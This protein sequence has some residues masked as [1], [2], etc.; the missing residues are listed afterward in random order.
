MGSLILS[1]MLFFGAIAPFTE[2]GVTDFDTVLSILNPVGIWESSG[3]EPWGFR[4]FEKNGW[5]PLT[6]GH[7]IYSDFGWFWKGDGAH[8]W[9]TDHYGAWKCGEEGTWRWFP[10]T[11]WYPSGVDWRGTK[12][13][14]GWRFSAINKKG[15]FEETEE[16]RVAR[17]EEWVWVAR[18]NFSEPLSRKILT[19][20][21]DGKSLLEESE[22]LGHRIMTYREIHRGGPDPLDYPKT[23]APTLPGI[24]KEETKVSS[25]LL[26]SLPTFWTPLPPDARPEQ[27]YCYRP[28]FY[29]DRDG[30]QRRVKIWMNPKERKEAAEKL[31]QTLIPIPTK[32]TPVPPPVEKPVKPLPPV[33]PKPESKPEKPKS[34][35]RFG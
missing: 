6:E 11:E 34:P 4:P 14:I 19:T 30:L 24:K 1:G 21:I 9:V 28:K 18:E 35:Y 12:T 15:E 26:M 8:S 23:Q 10:G 32:S 3:S 29:Q 7:W 16:A 33:E 20:G 2:R 5:R 27:V 25:Y 31:N 17:P 22:P 13:H